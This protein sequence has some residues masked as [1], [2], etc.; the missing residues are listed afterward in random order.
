MSDAKSAD[1][2]RTGEAVQ[3][4]SP[5]VT[6][7]RPGIQHA[8]QIREATLAKALLVNLFDESHAAKIVKVA[9]DHITD[10]VCS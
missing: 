7:A 10:D 5:G 3:P 8:R 9:Q 6:S 4:A 1:E 2:P